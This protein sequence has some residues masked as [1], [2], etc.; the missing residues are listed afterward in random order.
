MENEPVVRDIPNMAVILATV[1]AMAGCVALGVTVHP[2]W[3]AMA[4]AALIVGMSLAPR[5]GPGQPERWEPIEQVAQ[6]VGLGAV[7]ASVALSLADGNWWWLA[8]GVLV[9]ALA[10]VVNNEL[11]KPK[12]AGR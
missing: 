10:A 8:G 7:P 6:A 5:H 12:A 9:M 2:A 11:D 1:V 4:V 3:Y